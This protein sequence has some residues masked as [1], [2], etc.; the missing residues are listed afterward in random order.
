MA[1]ENLNQ[2]NPENSGAVVAQIRQQKRIKKQQ[3]PSYKLAGNQPV[4][5]VNRTRNKEAILG[6]NVNPNPLRTRPTNTTPLQQKTQQGAQGIKQ[7]VGNEEKSAAQAELRQSL[8]KKKNDKKEKEQKKPVLEPTSVTI[9][10]KG[11]RRL[12]LSALILT[13]TT[14][15]AGLPGLLFFFVA[16]QFSQRFPN[17]GEWIQA[18]LP[19]I[20]E[21]VGKRL[22]NYA[23]YFEY[24]VIAFAS[25]FVTIVAFGIITV[26]VGMA[27]LVPPICSK[28]VYDALGVIGYYAN[29]GY[30]LCEGIS[31]VLNA[32]GDFVGFTR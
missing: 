20:P 5:D 14:V 6:Q 25:G 16:G 11:L 24:L 3:R 31:F 15:F 7:T 30:Y 17:H 29:L 8:I 22:A 18:L 2:V 10:R 23:K 13:I 26:V 12:Y 9:Q 28:E 21:P 19:T 1:T 32:A 27:G 4:R